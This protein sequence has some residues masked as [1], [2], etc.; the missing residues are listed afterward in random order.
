MDMLLNLI[1]VITVVGFALLDFW[2]ENGKENI[3]GLIIYAIILIAILT[4]LTYELIL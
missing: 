3:K 4:I 1:I 2:M